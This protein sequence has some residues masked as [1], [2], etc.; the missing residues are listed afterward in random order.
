[1]HIYAN[2]RAH[3]AAKWAAARNVF[4]PI[5]S[6]SSYFHFPLN[7]CI[8]QEKKIEKKIIYQKKKKKHVEGLKQNSYTIMGPV[9]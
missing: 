4:G 6:N 2:E 9:M 7:V 3:V 5:A 1:M 8:A